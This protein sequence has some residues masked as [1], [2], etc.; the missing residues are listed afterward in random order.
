MPL[1]LLGGPYMELVGASLEL[2]LLALFVEMWGTGVPGSR[3]YS[4]PT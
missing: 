1:S 4:G 3:S 2:P